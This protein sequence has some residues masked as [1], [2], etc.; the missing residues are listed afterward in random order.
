MT[1]LI[2]IAYN[3]QFIE[4]NIILFKSPNR[5]GLR[6]FTSLSAKSEQAGK[7]SEIWAE[8]LSGEEGPEQSAAAGT[9]SC[10][11]RWLIHIGTW[12]TSNHFCLQ[13][14]YAKKKEKKKRQFIFLKLWL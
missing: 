3:L 4:K 6:F 8:G 14:T 10:F 1:A 7:Q 5:G 11:L 2:E 13:R 12:Q 9:I